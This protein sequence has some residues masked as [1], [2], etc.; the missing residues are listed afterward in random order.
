MKQLDQK[1]TVSKWCSLRADGDSDIAKTFKIELVIPIG[2]T[3]SDM[4]RAILKNEVIRFQ[5]K[6]RPKW[7][8]MVDK[9]THTITFKKPIDDIDP[10]DAMVARLQSMTPEE[11]SNELT[12]LATMIT[13]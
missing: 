2:T 6:S 1:L 5:N 10:F 4:A 9:S 11:Q 12:K 3:A 13:K 7:S 8:K